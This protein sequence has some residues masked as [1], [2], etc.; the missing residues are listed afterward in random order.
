MEVNL[1]TTV[2][3]SNVGD[4]DD[5][6]DDGEDDDGEC[7]VVECT[8]FARDPKLRRRHHPGRLGRLGASLAL[9]WA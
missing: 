8:V 3:Y 7:T 4:E 2:N 1:L 9:G 5:G 6:E